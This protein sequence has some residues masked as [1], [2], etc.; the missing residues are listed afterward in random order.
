MN[1]LITGGAGYIGSHIVQQFLHEQHQVIVLD[2]LVTGHRE[3]VAKEAI[4]IEGDVRDQALLQEIFSTYPI[5]AVVHTASSTSVGEST[6]DP[7]SYFDNNVGGLLSLAKAMHA[8]QVNFLILSS[9]AAVYGS[10]KEPLLDEDTPTQPDNP[11]GASK[12]MMETILEWMQKSQQIHVVALRYF[13]VAGASLTQDIGEDHTPETHLIPNI[14]AVP[15]GKKDTFTI[16]GSNYATPDGTTIR[17]YIHVSDVASIHTLA[18]DYLIQT[19]NSTTFNVGSGT[20]ISTKALVQTIAKELNYPIPIDYDTNRAGDSHTLI[21]SIHKANNE[22]D[23]YP[24][25]S[26]LAT[27]ITSA[28]NWHVEYPDGYNSATLNKK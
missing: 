17:D 6:T 3:A 5:D 10:A 26:D 12:L 25:H 24:K 16:F 8:F 21:A 9:S 7:L 15:L 23:W 13:N 11:Y 22:L 19:K 4:F 14:L 20:G 27:I 28:F 1:I 18:L 2:N